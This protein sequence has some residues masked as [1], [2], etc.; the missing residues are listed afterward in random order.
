MVRP[1]GE[2]TPT[3]GLDTLG[4]PSSAHWGGLLGGSFHSPPASGTSNRHSWVGSVN[5][6]GEQNS[7]GFFDWRANEDP[8]PGMED[9]RVCCDCFAGNSPAQNGY[10][11]VSGSSTSIHRTWNG[12]SSP[13]R[14]SASELWTPPPGVSTLDINRRRRRQSVSC[15]TWHRETVLDN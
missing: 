9:V 8:P 12:S 3:Q 1:P 2:V 10:R 5:T 14:P 4:L 15:D 13:T 7:I 11:S 6:P